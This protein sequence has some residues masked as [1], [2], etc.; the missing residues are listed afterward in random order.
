MNFSFNLCKTNIYYY[1]KISVKFDKYIN[2]INELKKYIYLSYLSFI[3]I[4]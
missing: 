3:M 1:Y 4:L 2:K